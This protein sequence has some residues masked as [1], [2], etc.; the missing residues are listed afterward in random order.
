MLESSLAMSSKA[1]FKLCNAGDVSKIWGDSSLIP[2]FHTTSKSPLNDPHFDM[3]SA[4]RAMSGDVVL[5][6]PW[7]VLTRIDTR[8]L[9]GFI[10]SG[11]VRSIAPVAA[12]IGGAFEPGRCL[13]HR[14]ELPSHDDPVAALK[15]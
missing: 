1:Y 8:S 2:S 13:Q 11:L 15:G 14:D 9:R 4:K 7:L 12:V 10:V 6:F 5:A 3:V